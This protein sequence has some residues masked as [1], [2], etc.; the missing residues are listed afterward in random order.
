MFRI[1]Q[2]RNRMSFQPG[3]NGWE[4]KDFH[5]KIYYGPKALQCLE[6]FFFWGLFLDF[7]VVE[8]IVVIANII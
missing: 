7:I 3:H 6:G 5:P 4:I 1:Y 2:V 8:D